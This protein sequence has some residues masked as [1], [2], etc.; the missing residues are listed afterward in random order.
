[1]YRLNETDA[2][3]E[4]LFASA[5]QRSE[6]P[7]A[8]LVARE[9]SRMI[10]ELGVD[11]CACRVAQEFGDHPDSARDRMQWARR[12]VGELGPESPP[13]ARTTLSCAA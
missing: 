7:S 3:C 8:G 12:V 11:G 10:R 1:M 6:A 13:F 2:R 4:A 5:L 9:I